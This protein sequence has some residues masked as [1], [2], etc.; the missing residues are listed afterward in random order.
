MRVWLPGY[1]RYVDTGNS[2]VGS[3]ESSSFFKAK[4]FLHPA[5]TLLADVAY[6]SDNRCVTPY[7]D[8]QQDCPDPVESQRRTELNQRLSSR[9]HP[10]RAHILSCQAHL[11]IAAEHVEYGPR[12]RCSNFPCMLP[13]F[14]IYWLLR[15][16]KLY[17]A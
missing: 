12:A 3:S 8:P 6:R 17:S 7:T 16:R 5:L 4:F 1:I 15:S 9:S 2:P 11:A 10:R 14:E 13:A